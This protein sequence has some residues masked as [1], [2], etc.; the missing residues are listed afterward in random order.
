MKEEPLAGCVF[1]I[2]DSAGKVLASDVPSLACLAQIVTNVIGFAFMFLG[3]VTLLMLLWGSIRFITS[4]GD[5]KA[6]L[7]ARQTMMY[8]IIGAVVVLMAFV[9]V[10]IVTTTLGGPDILTG[11]TLYQ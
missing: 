4:A 10:N 6:I 2:K 9:L 3:A 1:T 8:A 11:F 7:A 5:P